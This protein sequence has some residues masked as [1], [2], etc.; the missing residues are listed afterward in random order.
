M[1]KIDWYILKKFLSTFGFAILAI[2]VI[3]VVIDTS[4]KADDFV[5]S[6]LSSLQIIRR[7]HF[8]FIP[9]IIALIFPLIVFIAVIFFTSKMAGRSEIV[10]ILAS[11]TSYRRMLRPYIVG[12]A[13]LAGLLWWSNRYI[14]PRANEIRGNFQAKYID[15]NSGYNASKSTS[16]FYYLRE[17]SSTYIGMR[18]YDTASKTASSFFL[19]R[20]KN[21]N[22]VYNLRAETI[23][24]DTITKGWIL[25]NAVERIITGMKEQV[26][27]IPTKPIKFN[28]KP[29]DLRKDEYLKDKLTTP[30]LNEFIRLETLRGSEG[31]NALKVE[32]YRRDATPA[33]VLILTIIGAVV[34]SRK[35]RGGSGFHLATGII[36]GSVFILSDR[37]SSVFSVKGSLPAIV[38]AWIPNLLFALVAWWLYR[39]APK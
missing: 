6:G 28:F 38:A 8:G 35:I 24:W 39:R 25:D 11:G 20:F 5:K 13:L 12:G 18:Y 14:V 30:E 29:K 16:N 34:A 17:D 2:T 19:V 27:M 4:E 15:A 36:I 23:R 31:L 33:A 22:L 37:F 32:A 1:K 26:N 3:A 9:H 21:N 10:A 7:Y